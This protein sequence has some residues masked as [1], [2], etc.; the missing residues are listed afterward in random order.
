MSLGFVGIIC[1]IVFGDV[2]LETRQWLQTWTVWSIILSNHIHSEEAPAADVNTTTTL[3]KRSYMYIIS[4]LLGH[5]K[6][7]F[8]KY[9]TEYEQRIID[10][11]LSCS[12]L[13]PIC[14]LFTHVYCLS[15]LYSR[16][17]DGWIGINLT[18]S[19]SSGSKLYS[20]NYLHSKQLEIN[21]I[22][23]LQRV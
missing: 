3:I 8:K 20:H 2:H 9:C 4:S 19:E 13:H 18:Y 10:I 22:P 16:R 15:V 23:R 1:F 17:W 21:H 7:F 12:S 5:C 6:Q 11:F 14:F